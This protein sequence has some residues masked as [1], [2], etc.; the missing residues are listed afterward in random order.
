MP[1]SNLV[2]S[3]ALA[4]AGPAAQTPGLPAWA[5]KPPP[6]LPAEMHLTL[7][8]FRYFVDCVATS[9]WGDSKALFDTPI[10]SA[11]ESAMLNKITGGVNGSTCTYAWQMRMTS[12]ILRGGIAE[13]RYRYA[14]ARK[15]AP[16]AVPAEPAP[17]AAGAS[18]TWVAFNKE[19]TPQRLYAFANCLA[20]RETGGVH[21]V[22][23]TRWGS[24]EE[25]VAYQGLSRRFGTCLAP[26]QT[27]RANSLTLR[28]W[29][30][31]ALYQ[32]SRRLKPD[33]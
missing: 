24:K 23:T 31:E 27:L 15:G 13:A 1:L 6:K 20:E 14:Y 30:G 5:V 33:A 29:L 18:F 19:S 4:A 21:A 25:R 2:I 16:P 9:E 8:R 7:E 17:V 10:G 26:G 32:Y 12:M 28:P 3:A 11:A 22:L